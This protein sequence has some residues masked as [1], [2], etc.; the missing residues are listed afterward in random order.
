[1]QVSFAH[2]S[3]R[4]SN[5]SANNAGVTV[6][7]IGISNNIRQPKK[8]YQN[9]ADGKMMETEVSNISAYLVPSKDIYIEAKS[10]PPKDR[11]LMIYGNKPTDGG[12]L[13]MSVDDARNISIG[14]PSSRGFLRPYFGS[15]DFIKGSKRVCIWVE[16][17]EEEAAFQIPEFKRRFEAVSEFRSRSKAKETRSAAGLGHKFRQIQGKPGNKSIIV[18]IVSSETRLQLPIGLLPQGGIVSNSAFAIYDAP[19]WNLAILASHLHLVWIATVCGKLKT[20]YRY[21]NTLGWN[22]FPVPTLTEKIKLI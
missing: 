15:E 11:P 12:N 14:N 6:V 3:F 20:D 19:I 22:T 1:V 2:L 13:V 9:A 4:W 8:I 5:L 10:K 21:S 7:I 18:P 17:N 16:D